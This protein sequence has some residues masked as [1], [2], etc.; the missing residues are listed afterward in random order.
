MTC[1]R[2]AGCGEGFWR[3]PQ[4]PQQ[5]YCGR[6]AC[7]RE[8]RRRWQQSKRQADGDY[9]ANQARAPRTWAAGHREYW[10]QWRA[11]HPEYAERNRVAQRHRDRERQTS[12]LAKMDA[13]PPVSR[14]ASGTYR[15]VPC[16]GEDL[17]K[18][19]ACTVELTV[20]SGG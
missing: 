13:S 18:M 5:R 20:I 11:A 3:R 17:A 6:A 10:R 16:T 8:R 12:G 19:D 2:C 1:R 14:I 9:R 4:V 15:L 7:Q